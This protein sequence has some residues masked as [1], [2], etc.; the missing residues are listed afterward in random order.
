MRK[1]LSVLVFL[2]LALAPVAST[3]SI[4]VGGT[5]QHVHYD[6]SWHTAHEVAEIA[7][8]MHSYDHMTGHELHDDDQSDAGDAS[9]PVRH[10]HTDQ[11]HFVSFVPPT[12]MA[13]LAPMT[14]LNHVRVDAPIP[15]G[16]KTYPPFRP[17]LAA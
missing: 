13:W 5:G 17:P 16:Q 11:A 12:A 15:L 6:S 1:L 3:L 10:V 2:S 7:S 8:R 9:G 4:A 14:A